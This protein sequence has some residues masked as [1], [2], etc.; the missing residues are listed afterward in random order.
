MPFI[1]IGI[2]IN[3]FYIC[4]VIRS[5]Y[6]RI[7]V[8]VVVALVPRLPAHLAAAFLLRSCFLLSDFTLAF[9]FVLIVL[10]LFVDDDHHHDDVF[11][12]YALPFLSLFC[13][14]SVCMCIMLF[15]LMQCRTFSS[16][17]CI[18]SIVCRFRIKCVCMYV[19]CIWMYK[20]MRGYFCCR[21]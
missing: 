19:H 18:V 1:R 7:I 20:L 4:C 11:F 12:S 9:F 6:F 2:L 16:F 15:L 5:N 8:F 13:P 21:S 17:R 3:A 14:R 10:F